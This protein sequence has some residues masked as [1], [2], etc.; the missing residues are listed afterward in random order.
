MGSG[1]YKYKMIINSKKTLNFVLGLVLAI[2]IV[3]QITAFTVSM[4]FME[5]NKL[6]L[7]PGDSYNMDFVVQNPED[8]AAKINIIQGSEIISEVNESEFYFVLAKTKTKIPLLINIPS[9]AQLGDRYDIEI[10]IST[11]PLSNS[12]EFS[13]GSTISQSF[14][15]FLEE[16]LI[17]EKSSPDIEP[18]TERTSYGVWILILAIILV[19][20]I[21]IKLKKNKIKVKS[22]K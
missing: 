9:S 18:E 14:E 10:K 7:M 20:V 1:Q 22:K 8:I 6:R 19:L 16:P 4:P 17:P 2:F 3:S 12:G 21:I 5:D 15:I 11:S 13:F